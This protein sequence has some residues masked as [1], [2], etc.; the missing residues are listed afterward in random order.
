MGLH[1]RRLIKPLS[2]PV[3]GTNAEWLYILDR[4]IPERGNAQQ[5]LI[6]VVPPFWIYPVSAGETTEQRRTIGQ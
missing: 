5:S 1:Q 6:F 2:A 3:K 4:L